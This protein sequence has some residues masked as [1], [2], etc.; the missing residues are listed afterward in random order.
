MPYKN[1]ERQEEYMKE[2]LKQW[3]RNHPEYFEKWREDNPEYYKIWAKNNHKKIRINYNRWY[4]K[5]YKTNPKFKLD[6]N[7]KDVIG[8]SLKN[9]AKRSYWEKLLGYTSNE[10][11]KHLQKTIPDGYIW[12][13]YLEGKLHIDHIIPKSAF[14]YIKVEHPDFKRCWALKNLRL[15]PSKENLMKNSELYKPFQPT[16]QISISK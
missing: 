8:N 4:N 1:R 15:L 16:L 3:R 5:K 13:D 7:I 9:N 11:K 6:K 10:L 12:Q 2:Y 14:N